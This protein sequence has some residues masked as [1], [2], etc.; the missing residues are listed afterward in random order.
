L[1]EG[2]KPHHLHCERENE[3]RLSVVKITSGGSTVVQPLA[4]DPKAEG[5]RP[6]IDTGDFPKIAPA[7][8]T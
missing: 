1:A 3:R 8:V 2:S 5:L 4:H 6:A 7:V